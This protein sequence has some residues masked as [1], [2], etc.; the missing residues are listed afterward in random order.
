MAPGMGCSVS[1][2]RPPGL[3]VGGPAGATACL[4]VVPVAAE[5]HLDGQ[6]AVG[7]RLVLAAVVWGGDTAGGVGHQ[8]AVRGDGPTPPPPLLEFYLSAPAS[9]P[10]PHSRD[11]TDPTN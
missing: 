8:E 10:P 11:V 6:G 2:E 4:A 1:E 3:G 5:V 7:A 9:L